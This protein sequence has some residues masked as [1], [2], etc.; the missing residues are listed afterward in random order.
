M[1]KRLFRISL[2][3]INEPGPPDG[4]PEQLDSVLVGIALG[5]ASCLLPVALLWIVTFTATDLFL[6]LA[7]AF[8]IHAEIRHAQ[9]RRRA[10]RTRTELIGRLRRLAPLREQSRYFAGLLTEV[11]QRYHRLAFVEIF[12]A[13]L[14]SVGASAAIAVLVELHVRFR[15]V[16]VVLPAFVVAAASFAWLRLAHWQVRSMLPTKFAVLTLLL[17]AATS[18]AFASTAG[19]SRTDDSPQAGGDRTSVTGPDRDSRTSEKPANFGISP[20]RVSLESP[21]RRSHS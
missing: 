2:D 16:D 20:G 13:P 14:V 11:S 15:L 19:A 18:L 9:G 8:F 12:V 17:L 1:S 21:S 4:A 5:C 3:Q 7:L 6:A 10:L